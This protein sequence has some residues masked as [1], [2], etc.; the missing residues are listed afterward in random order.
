MSSG[1]HPVLHM[2]LFTTQFCIFTSLAA[3]NRTMTE[4]GGLQTVRDRSSGLQ[5]LHAVRMNGPG[6]VL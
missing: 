6:L 1:A 2:M 5:G 4:L 3:G